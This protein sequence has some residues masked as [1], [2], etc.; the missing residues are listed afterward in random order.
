M[1]VTTFASMALIA[2]MAAANSVPIY[3]THPGWIQGGGEANIDIEIFMDYL[4]SDTKSLYPA[5]LG[6]METEVESGFTVLDA[7]TLK[8]SPFPMDFHLHSW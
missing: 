5:F 7:V 2:G 8:V 4:C 1:N 3:G 6:A